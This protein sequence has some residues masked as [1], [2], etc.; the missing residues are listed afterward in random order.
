MSINSYQD[1]IVFQKA[2]SLSLEIHKFSYT[3][4]SCEQFELASQM[5]KS[6]KSVCANLAEGFAKQ[7]YSKAEYRRF[8]TIAIGSINELHLWIKYCIDLEY[9][10]NAAGRVFQDQ[11]LEIHKMLFAIHAKWQ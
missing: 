3:L 6:S 1:L 9:I 4:P 2:Y 8:L 7:R 5:R 11:C 10:N